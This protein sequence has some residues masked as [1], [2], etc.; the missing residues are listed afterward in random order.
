MAL[1]VRLAKNATSGAQP[2]LWIRTAKRPFYVECNGGTAQI[3]HSVDS[4][5][6]ADS[7]ATWRT[8]GTIT[9]GDGMV[10]DHPVYRIRA[11]V[12]AGTA[13]VDMLEGGPASS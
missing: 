6:T 12:T 2:S 7:A 8:L 10:I 4:P 1:R 11:N 13:T 9:S 5:S 3:Q